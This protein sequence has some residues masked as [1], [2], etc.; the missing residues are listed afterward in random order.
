M[1][2]FDGVRHSSS[3]T[4]LTMYLLSLLLPLGSLHSIYTQ[5]G[6]P[7]C[8]RIVTK[9][10]EPDCYHS[11]L[12]CR[13]APS[14]KP[15]ATSCPPG[16]QLTEVNLSQSGCTAIG[17][18]GGVTPLEN[19]I[20]LKCSWGYDCVRALS[21]HSF[22]SSGLAKQKLTSPSVRN[23]EGVSVVIASIRLQGFL[24]AEVEM[25]R[26]RLLRDR[27][28]DRGGRN[29]SDHPLVPERFVRRSGRN[30]RDSFA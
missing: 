23:E 18:C 5:A 21:L 29:C 20:R 15:S 24:E 9:T 10:C 6:K 4:Y 12:T 26:W 17:T 2:E 11:E 8:R 7:N 14:D 25:D 30:E 27:A 13:I 16:Q 1:S 19:Y 22:L 3:R 28:T